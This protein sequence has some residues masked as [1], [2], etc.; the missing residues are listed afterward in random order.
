MRTVVEPIEDETLARRFIAL[1]SARDYGAFAEL[2]DPD[3]VW[4]GTRGGMDA[5]RVVRGP[6]AYLAYMREV[7][8]TFERYEFEVEETFRFEGGVLVYLWER[9]EGR[10]G[11]QLESRTAI[12]LE[13]RDGLVHRVQGYVDRD[14][15]R[16]ESGLD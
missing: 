2:L 7:L 6:D 15:A 5:E 14:E 13:I 9:G 11:I 12:A 8:G 1:A 3:V 4:S 10:D 16:R